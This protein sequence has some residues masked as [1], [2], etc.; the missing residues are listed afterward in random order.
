M[1]TA[2]RIPSGVTTFAQKGDALTIAQ[3]DSNW[4]AVAGN[5]VFLQSATG[6]DDCDNVTR[7]GRYAFSGALASGSANY[8][9]LSFFGLNVSGLLD[10]DNEQD[11]NIG[12]N[13][14][15]R[16][17]PVSETTGPFEVTLIRTRRYG[18]WT[19]WL[20]K[21]LVLESFANFPTYDMGPILVK[22]PYGFAQYKWNATTNPPMYIKDFDGLESQTFSTSQSAMLPR[23]ISRFDCELVGGGGAG[24]SITSSSTGIAYGGSGGGASGSIGTGVVYDP[25]R[26]ANGD[27]FVLIGIGA[28]GEPNTSP[29]MNG[30]GGAGGQTYVTSGSQTRS[31]PGGIGGQAGQGNIV[32]GTGGSINSGLPNAYGDN[33]SYYNG[34][35]GGKSPIANG[36]GRGGKI[37]SNLSPNSGNVPP[38]RA[39]G[40]GG[41]GSS[42]KG[43]TSNLPSH[44]A[45][46]FG[47]YVT[48]RW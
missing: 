31:I 27:I 45:K 42:G 18:Q 41:G 13:I 29:E 17:R 48:L 34:G 30:Q 40:A 10:V 36:F 9:N 47:G 37:G 3:M 44:G 23:N 39:Y 32:G 26:D 7:S 1:A 35:N 15:Q 25:A 8:P 33:G 24:G 12:A 43:G 16:V 11:F 2:P 20:V 21:G 19:P 46:G 5:R 28:A 38:T 22:K 4:E 14:T 6:G